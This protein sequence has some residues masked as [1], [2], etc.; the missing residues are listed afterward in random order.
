MKTP[1]KTFS[2]EYHAQGRISVTA[3]NR[4]L[5]YSKNWCGYSVKVFY[6]ILAST[7][8]SNDFLHFY[9]ILLTQPCH[10]QAKVPLSLQSGANA[11]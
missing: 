7:E 11:Q 1:M 8:V 9:P 3:S 2:Q 6:I 5:V 10:S 4:D